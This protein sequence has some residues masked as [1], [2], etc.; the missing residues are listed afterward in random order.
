MWSLLVDTGKSCNFDSTTMGKCNAIQLYIMWRE[1]INLWNKT[2]MGK[3]NDRNIERPQGHVSQA[4]QA[5][6]LTR[7]WVNDNRKLYMTEVLPS[8][9]GLCPPVLHATNTNIKVGNLSLLS[10]P[11]IYSSSARQDRAR[12]DHRGCGG[13]CQCQATSRNTC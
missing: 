9:E 7:T 10:N 11:P 5:K 12:H 8:S 2:N 6:Q 4:N 1:Q 13:T 3:H